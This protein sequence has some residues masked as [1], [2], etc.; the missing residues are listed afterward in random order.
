MDGRGRYLDNIFIERLWRN[1]KYEDI[2]IWCYESAPEL[3]VGLQRYFPF[4]NFERPHQALDDRTPAQLY[5]AAATGI[6]L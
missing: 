2:Y 5:H 6:S 3:L 1:V 4:Y